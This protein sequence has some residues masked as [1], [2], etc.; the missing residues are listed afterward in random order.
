V[1]V[2]LGLPMTALAFFKGFY[3]RGSVS[4]FIPA[5]AMVLIG[6]YWIWVIGL[7]G[8]LLMEVEEIDISLDYSGLLMLI[9]L[10]S[11][12]GWCTTLW[13]SSSTV[14]SGREGGFKKDLEKKSG[15]KKALERPAEPLDKA[16]Q[17]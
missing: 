15:K 17:P 11:G 9:M 2:L 5:E 4:R 13:S 16:P 14:R 12:S 6:L 10:G 7:E 3:P 1:V 8:K